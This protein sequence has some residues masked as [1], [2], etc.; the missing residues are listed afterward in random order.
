MLKPICSLA[1]ASP[2]LNHSTTYSSFQK[3]TTSLKVGSDSHFLRCSC[4]QQVT[5]AWAN[6]RMLGYISLKTFLVC[7]ER[8]ALTEQNGKSAVVGLPGGR[9]VIGRVLIRCRWNAKS[10]D[11]SCDA[12]DKGMIGI[13]NVVGRLAVVTTTTTNAVQNGGMCT[14]LEDPCMLWSRSLS[15]L[16][17]G[18]ER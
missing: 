2:P 15:S 9:I 13:C 6:S 18:V 12:V 1:Y 5:H 14:L 17:P 7:S 16:F 11:W 8:G 10:V 3:S 4:P